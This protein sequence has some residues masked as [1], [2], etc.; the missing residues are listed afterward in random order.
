MSK[1]QHSPLH[2]NVDVPHHRSF[3]ASLFSLSKLSVLAKIILTAL[4]QM[5]NYHIWCEGKLK[6]FIV[7]ASSLLTDQS[8]VDL[9][10]VVL[11]DTEVLNFRVRCA[12][13]KSL[14]KSLIK[15]SHL[16]NVGNQQETCKKSLQ[17][18][19]TPRM[20]DSLFHENVSSSGVGFFVCLRM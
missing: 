15:V 20:S 6:S 13:D 1:A 3:F 2:P 17:K 11:A 19:Q 5:Q 18:S 7:P 16:R 8:L 14:N 10:Q 12:F 9:I 4:T